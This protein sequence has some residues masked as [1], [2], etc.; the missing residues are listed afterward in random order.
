MPITHER[1][2]LFARER[3][4][5]AL[6]LWQGK[7]TWRVADA[8]PGLPDGP[9]SQHGFACETLAAR[10]NPRAALLALAEAVRRRGGEIVEHVSADPM[11]L[12]NDGQTVVVAAGYE[13]YPLL[14]LP[15]GSGVKGQAALLASDAFDDA[16][17]YLSLI[18]I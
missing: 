13:S 14:T 17:I 6:T 7:A 10:V 9:K 8:A 18:H 4:E 2:A 16:P 5:E 11:T 12:A 15:F 3:S 1:G